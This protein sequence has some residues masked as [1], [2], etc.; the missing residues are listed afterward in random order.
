MGGIFMAYSS[1]EKEFEEQCHSIH[2]DIDASIFFKDYNY[3]QQR[4]P[5]LGE[6]FTAL[7]QYVH[8]K[9]PNID[10]SFTARLKAKKSSLIKK[11]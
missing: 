1:I 10:F 3:Y 4:I 8:D 9:L 6:K 7:H 2:S 11:C 5:L